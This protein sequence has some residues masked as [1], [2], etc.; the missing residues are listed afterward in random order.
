MHTKEMEAINMGVKYSIVI[1]AYNSEKTIGG[2]VNKISEVFINE[3]YE[4]ILINDASSDS[5]SKVCKA[6]AVENHN[7][8][9]LELS[10]NFGQ[11][12]AIIAGFNYVSGD[13][14]I[15]MD[16]DLQNPPEEIF[17]LTNKIDEGYDVVYG[18]YAEKKHSTARNF[19]SLVNDKMAQIMIQKPKEIYFSSFRIIKRYVIDEI[20]KYDA[21]YCYIDGLILRVTRNISM[22][23]VV[24]KEREIGESNYNI[25]SLLK[26]WMNGFT[27]FSVLPLRI[28]TFS[29][30]IFSFIGFIF[31]I[32]LIIMKFAT[33]VQLGWTSIMVV[34]VFFCGIQLISI[35]LLGEYIGRIFMSINK[36]PQYIVKEVVKNKTIV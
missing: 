28:A 27:S 12:N 20:I 17:K 2:L 32:F 29:G 10:K 8:V 34:V 22:V 26:L 7:V 13:Y 14:I 11:H 21:P 19:G 6:L 3:K 1:P 5:T 24:H 25:F 23:E 33:D 36:S 30:F 15:T 4:I 16:D 35:G 31:M 9:F 18:K